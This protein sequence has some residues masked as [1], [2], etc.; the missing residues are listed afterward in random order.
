MARL[1]GRPRAALAV[2]ALGVSTS[3]IF[4]ELSGAS[5]GTATFFRCLLALPLLWPL[6]AGERR[7]ESTLSWPRRAVALAA[8]LLFCRGRTAVDP[9]DP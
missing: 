1:S 5:P 4:I 7:R 9:G 3:A 6:A 2:G 8:G